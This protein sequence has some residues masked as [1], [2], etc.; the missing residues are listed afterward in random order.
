MTPLMA[1]SQSKK[2][3]IK[4]AL[5]FVKQ[6]KQDTAEKT[7]AILYALADKF[8]EESDLEEVKEVVA[9]TRLGQMLYDDGVEAGR[10][11]GLARGRTE[12]SDKMA[13]LTKILLKAGRVS[14][15]ERA[16]D[17]KEYREK[18]MFE[19]GLEKQ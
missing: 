15:L 10:T 12:G 7:L 5:Q 1:S 3:V 2:E 9:M 16:A 8:L 13:S 4:Q 14:D 19:C 11:E 18:L 6:D 17:D